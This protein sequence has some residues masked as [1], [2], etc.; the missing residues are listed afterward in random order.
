MSERSTG[1]NYVAKITP[2]TAPAA[3]R[4][5]KDA[6]LTPQERTQYLSVTQ[7]LSWPARTTMPGLCS[8]V[9]ELQQ[10]ANR[11]TVTDLLQA[12][13]VLKVVQQMARDGACVWF[14]K[15]LWIWTS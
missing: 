11:A 3:R 2:I 9:S 14:R 5:C 10:K 12:N 1:I 4:K 6:L 13:A 7:Q 15:P 8:R